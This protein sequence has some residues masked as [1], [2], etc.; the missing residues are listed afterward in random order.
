M[1]DTPATK[2]KP[3]LT[4]LHLQGVASN[5]GISIDGKRSEIYE[6]IQQHLTEHRDSYKD[7]T[8]SIFNKVNHVRMWVHASHVTIVF[9]ASFSSSEELVDE[10][11]YHQLPWKVDRAGSEEDQKPAHRLPRKASPASS[12]DKKSVHQASHTSLK[13]V[14]HRLNVLVTLR[15]VGLLYYFRASLIIA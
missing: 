1:S 6:R 5:L 7:E 15:A 14:N 13:E 10:P 2:S 9:I 12:E 11:V 8:L 4:K 3:Y